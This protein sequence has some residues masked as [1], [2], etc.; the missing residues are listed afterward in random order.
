MGLPM[1]TPKPPRRRRL[2]RYRI[3]CSCASYTWTR[4]K[5]RGVFMRCRGCGKLL[6]DME[7]DYL[8][9]EDK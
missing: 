8:G 5:Q 9:P 6:G 4:S 2:Y 1:N 3:N 7:V